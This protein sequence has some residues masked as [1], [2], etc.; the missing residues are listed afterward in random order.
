MRRRSLCIVQCRPN[1]HLDIGL[2][3]ERLP[4]FQSILHLK[5]NLAGYIEVTSSS[6]A[7]LL[8]LRGLSRMY[9]FFEP[10]PAE[11]AEK[12]LYQLS[13]YTKGGKTDVQLE[14]AKF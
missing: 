11:P 3:S 14:H 1:D 9:E 2:I 4:P 5:G 6:V 10:P 12:T 7:H 13:M 8:S